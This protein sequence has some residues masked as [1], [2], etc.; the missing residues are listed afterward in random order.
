MLM[1]LFEAVSFVL[2]EED[3]R[4]C[5]C[6]FML[7]KKRGGYVYGIYAMAASGRMQYDYKQTNISRSVPLQSTSRNARFC[8]ACAKNTKHFKIPSILYT[9]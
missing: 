4:L 8:N 1:L 6:F 5:F 7:R 9:P 3:S 2:G